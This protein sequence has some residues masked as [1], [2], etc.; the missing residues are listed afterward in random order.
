[1]K[2]KKISQQKLKIVFWPC[3][4]KRSFHHLRT[5]ELTE[6]RELVTCLH[7]SFVDHLEVLE[8]E[9]FSAAPGQKK[10]TQQ[11]GAGSVLM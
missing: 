10:G 6:K 3:M 11:W 1:M 7:G 8:A 4:E 2:W 5:D 9:S